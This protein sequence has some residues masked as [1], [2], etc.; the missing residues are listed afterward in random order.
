MGELSHAIFSDR[1]DCDRPPRLCHDASSSLLF[2]FLLCMFYNIFFI[3]V[4]IIANDQGERTL[5]S[6]VAFSSSGKR[7]LSPRNFV[8]V[9]GLRRVIM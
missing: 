6:Y 3:S 1:Q 2:N 8:G 4:E 5:P 7:A 9:D